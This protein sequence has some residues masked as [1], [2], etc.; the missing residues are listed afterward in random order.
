V[1]VLRHRRDLQSVFYLL[2]QP[3]LVLA[4]WQGYA[5]MSALIWALAYGLLIFL[6]IALS[7]VHHNHAHYR[8]WQNKYANR[9]CDHYISLLQGH[10]TFVFYASHNAIHHRYHHG[11]QDLTRTYRF[12][13]DSNHLLGFLIHPLQATWVLYPVF[14]RWIRRLWRRQPKVCLYYLSQYLWLLLLWAGALW[15][16]PQK[17]L[18]LVIVPQLIGLHWLLATNY[19]QHAHAD[20]YSSLNFS[21]NFT[22]LVN[23]LCFN[24]GLHT[25]HHL[26]PRRHWTELP[27]LHQDLLPQ[28]RPELQEHGLAQYLWR[29]LLLGSLFPAWR[30]QSLLGRSE[31]STPLP[32]PN[33]PTSERDSHAQRI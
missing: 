7:A 17:A 11:P 1:Q 9:I 4:M 8:L 6:C 29:R 15:L 25:A 26:H 20:G 19:L 2:A 12:G 30:S 3:A 21:R 33:N 23:L 10:P 5:V 28:L 22:G 18:W 24:I 16:Q 31:V 27:R 13:A 14:I 32:P